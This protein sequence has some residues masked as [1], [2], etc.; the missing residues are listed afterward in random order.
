MSKYREAFNLRDE[1]GTCP[2]I[3]VDLQII[4]RSPFFITLF[5]VKEEDKPMIDKEM[6][7]SVHLGILKKDMSPYSSPIMLIARKNF[8]LKKIITDFRYL[9][10]DCKE[11]IWPF[12]WLVIHLQFR[13]VPNVNA[14]QP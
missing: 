4:D 5:H 2:N 7:R 11:L 9:I 6:Q 3:E 12:H 8:G 13:E 14:Y 10:V 1:I